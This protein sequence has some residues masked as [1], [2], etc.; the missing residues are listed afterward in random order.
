MDMSRC[1]VYTRVSRKENTADLK[2]QKK[3][4]R[5]YAKQKNLRVA[6][7][8][9]EIVSGFTDIFKRKELAAA[10]NKCLLNKIGVLVVNDLSRLTRSVR[11]GIL[12]LDWTHRH[13]ITIYTAGNSNDINEVNYLDHLQE[14]LDA[15][16]F[17]NRQLSRKREGFGRGKPPKGYER[18]A[19]N[20]GV[21]TFDPQ[22]EQRLLL[23]F[24]EA[25]KLKNDHPGLSAAKIAN[26]LEAFF[27][28]LGDKKALRTIL[29][30]PIYTGRHGH[31]IKWERKD[32]EESPKIHYA[33]IEL[34]D[35]FRLNDKKTQQ[36]LLYTPLLRCA[37]CNVKIHKKREEL[38]CSQ[39]RKHVPISIFLDKTQAMCRHYIFDPDETLAIRL[40]RIGVVEKVDSI[41]QTIADATIP[42]KL[43]W[44]GTKK[45][46][47]VGELWQELRSRKKLC[48]NANT[49]DLALHFA[50]RR[51]ISDDGESLR[52]L[53]DFCF[54][55][56]VVDFSNKDISVTPAK[57]LNHVKRAQNPLSQEKIDED[58][59][60]LT[61]D[62]THKLDL[63]RSIFAGNPFLTDY[64][65]YRIV[66]EAFKQ[67]EDVPT[68]LMDILRF[69]LVQ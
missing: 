16:R 55:T 52:E 54:E 1:V 19:G 62:A 46:K 58:I 2:N 48:L 3:K 68:F 30:S 7:E 45:P 37:S 64:I 65:S 31:G 56:L 8:H 32:V 40:T 57:L 6:Y 42:V 36:R 63:L 61:Q 9:S 12:I 51:Q 13:G 5:Q 59:T 39:C 10:L 20:P 29:R 49:H 43:G 22:L 27:S 35:F 24:R 50:I 44:G 25:A 18:S 28:D 34:A 17:Y 66:Q 69:E 23:F 53:I 4:V 60:K 15:E 14:L 41:I 11:D 26:E 33:Y 67:W 47:E 21:L 38:H